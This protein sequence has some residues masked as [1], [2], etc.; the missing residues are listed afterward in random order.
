MHRGLCVNGTG[1]LQ[2]LE[3]KINVSKGFTIEYGC[4]YRPGADLVLVFH[5]YGQ[6]YHDM[7]P[8][9]DA[10]IQHGYSVLSF[11]LFFHNGSLINFEAAEPVIEQTLWADFLDDLLLSYSHRRLLLFGFSMGARFVLSY[12]GRRARQVYALFLAAPDGLK[13]N[14]WNVIGTSTIVGRYV[15]KYSMRHPRFLLWLSKC[16]SR[17]NWLN[18]SRQKFVEHYLIH[19]QERERVLNTWLAF[20]K[21]RLKPNVLKQLAVDHGTWLYFFYGSHDRVIAPGAFPSVLNGFANVK[22]FVFNCGHSKLVWHAAQWIAS[23]KALLTGD[24]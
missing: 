23:N 3:H 9:A 4:H 15:F 22:K 14:P 2:M 8:I 24:G 6:C 19:A 16:L 10:F 1:E 12:Y 5:G 17:M 7:Q 21:L 18:K 11:N 20:R 13:L